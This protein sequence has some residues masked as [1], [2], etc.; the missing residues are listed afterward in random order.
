MQ[1]RHIVAM[2][3]DRKSYVAM[4]VTFIDLESHF[5]LYKA[6]S[7]SQVSASW[8]YIEYS[9]LTYE[10]CLVISIVLLKLKDVSRSQAVTCIVPVVMVQDVESLLPQTINRK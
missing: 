4:S 9:M 2:E 5:V 1:H 3:D 6:S 8:A 7:N 10:L